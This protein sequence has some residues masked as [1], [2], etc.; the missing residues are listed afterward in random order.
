MSNLTRISVRRGD[1]VQLIV[2]DA[3]LPAFEGER[4]STALLASGLLSWRRSQI[5]REPRG[6]YCGIGICFECIVD[7]ENMG[8]VRA[9]QTLVRDGMRV[10][11]IRLAQELA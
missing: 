7:V 9:C 6:L 3:P 11:T 5:L 4:L 1:P 2:N 10:R 8:V